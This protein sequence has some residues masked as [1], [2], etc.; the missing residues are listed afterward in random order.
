MANSKLTLLGNLFIKKSI[1]KASISRRT[2]ISKQ[3]L[4][5]LSREKRIRIL[6]SEVYLI[7]LTTGMEP[8]KLLDMV[9]NHLKE[10][11][12]KDTKVDGRKKKKKATKKKR[13]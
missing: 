12:K 3:R 8:G 7:A 11:V 13:K 4:T 9:C 5:R 1:N 10:K 2:G 6:A